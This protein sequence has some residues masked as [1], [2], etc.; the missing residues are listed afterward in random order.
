MIIFNK[1]MYDSMVKI[2]VWWFEKIGM[3]EFGYA[4]KTNFYQVFYRVSI[5]SVGIALIYLVKPIETVIYLFYVLVIIVGSYFYIYLNKKLEKEFYSKSSLRIP[6]YVHK[7]FTPLFWPQQFFKKKN[8]W[9]VYLFY[10]L[11]LLLF[12]I[13]MF[14]FFLLFN[15]ETIFQK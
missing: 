15:I 7:F 8:F 11:Q 1:K 3:P 6:A 13:V 2:N 14:A 5:F 4:F 9:K 10:F 12:F